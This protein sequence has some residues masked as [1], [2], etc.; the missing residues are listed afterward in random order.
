M[1]QGLFLEGL[2]GFEHS[3]HRIDERA[4]AAVGRPDEET[5]MLDGTKLRKREVNPGLGRVPE[6]G[7]V[8]QIRQ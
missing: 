4:D 8:G 7:V 2:A 6:P 3:P 1:H 5:P